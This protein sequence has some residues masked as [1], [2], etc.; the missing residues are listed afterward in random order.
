MGKRYI[1]AH[2]LCPFYH[3]EDRQK[4][5]CEGVVPGSSLHLAFGDAKEFRSYMEY[6]C[7]C[8]YNSCPIAKMLLAKY[9]G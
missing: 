1:S 8:N 2:A 7:R 4:I 6:Y 5:Y 9:E 3:S